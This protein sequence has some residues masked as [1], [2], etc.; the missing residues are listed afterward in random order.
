MIGPA[1]LVNYLF[2]YRMRVAWKQTTVWCQ[3]FV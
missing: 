1:S 2:G 3:W